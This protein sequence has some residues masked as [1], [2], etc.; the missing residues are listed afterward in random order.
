M[1]INQPEVEIRH[2]RKLKTENGQPKTEKIK[3]FY[4][5]IYAMKY[6]LLQTNF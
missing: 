6:V 1:S 2:S 3:Q 5:F 4:I